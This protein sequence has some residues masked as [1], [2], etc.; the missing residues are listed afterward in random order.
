MGSSILLSSCDKTPD[1]TVKWH[2][3]TKA[4]TKM[5]M[6]FLV[7]SIIIKMLNPLKRGYCL[8]NAVFCFNFN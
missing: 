1:I 8:D 6:M 2:H 5:I 4:N 3:L 7:L